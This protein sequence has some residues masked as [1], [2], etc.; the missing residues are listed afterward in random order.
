[1]RLKV[2]RIVL[3]FCGFLGCNEEFEGKGVLVE[4]TIVPT[5]PPRNRS[6]RTRIRLGCP[7]KQANGAV[8]QEVGTEIREYWANGHPFVEVLRQ[9]RH[10]GHP[11]SQS[12]CR[13]RHHRVRKQ[14]APRQRTDHAGD[15]E[16]GNE[17]HVRRTHYV[18]DLVHL[19][20]N[21][22]QIFLSQRHRRQVCCHRR[23]DPA[24]IGRQS[25]ST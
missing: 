19:L 11:H 18:G 14:D 12:F 24:A 17:L 7:P 25:G 16:I 13:S 5:N 15:E 6:Q 3:V 9:Q 1:M 4:E 10:V 2:K 22:F 23:G 8:C 21:N 20:A